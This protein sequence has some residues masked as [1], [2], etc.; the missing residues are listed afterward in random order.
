MVARIDDAVVAYAPGLPDDDVAIL[1]LRLTGRAQ[2]GEEP[3]A[4]DASALASLRAAGA[5]IVEGSMPPTPA[6]FGLTYGALASDLPA[7]IA[8]AYK[9]FFISASNADFGAA[10]IISPTTLPPLKNFKVGM[11]ITLY[12]IARLLFSSTLILAIVTL[13]AYSPASA[14]NEGAIILQGPH[15]S[16]QKSSKTGVE[17]LITSA[18]K[19]AS[20]T[21]LIRSLMVNGG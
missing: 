17:D 21:Y 13:P 12:F 18:S 20:L 15:H 10:P 19:L 6:A 2:A 3:L 5:Q 14:S 4:F 11:L 1:A 7:K 9:C 8:A 16:A